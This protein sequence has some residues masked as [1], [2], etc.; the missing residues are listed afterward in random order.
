[1]DKSGESGVARL[2]IARGRRGK[3]LNTRAFDR[4]ITSF[5]LLICI[6]V[7]LILLTRIRV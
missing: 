5:G 4:A 2:M 7:N 3:E 1:M 6:V